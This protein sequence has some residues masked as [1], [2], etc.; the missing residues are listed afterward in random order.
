VNGQPPD[1][2]L[3]QRFAELGFITLP[4]TMMPVLHQ[5]NKA[6]C[7]SD[8]TVLLEG[9]T[10]TGKQILAYAIHQL[11][12]K[13]RSFPFV[14]VHCGSI[15]EA[16]AES[17][18]F[19]HEQGAFS[20]AIRRRKGL[21]Q[22]A[23]QGTLFLDDVNDLPASLQPKLLDVLQRSAVRPVGADYEAR[24]DTRIIAA[25]N[26]P[27]APLVQHKQF[28]SDLYHRLNVVKLTLPP[29]RERPRDLPALLLAFAH[30][31]SDVYPNI[32]GVE[33]ALL[34]HL[35]SQP[36]WGNLRE[37][38][39][40]VQRMLFAKVEGSTL[41]LLDWHRQTQAG[42]A[43]S[44]QDLLLEAANALWRA[45]CHHGVPYGQALRQIDKNVLDAALRSGGT[46]RREVAL[47][48]Q[49]SERT[50]YHKLRSHKLSAIS[51]PLPGANPSTPR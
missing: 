15:N 26:Q 40:A 6:A 38:E 21:F 12:K 51:Q 44:G 20:G 35:E 25:S 22:A 43:E 10:G 41:L 18:L 19:G 1:D 48:L 42:P 49:T 17:E 2:E 16:L 45:I 32:T 34:H 8:I 50:L 46:T 5:A 36:F 27:L 9:E 30:R 13:R 3:C 47:R 11:D 24:I 7:V 28:R 39:H 37:L 4:N 33:P 29:L 23:H 31:H 14:T